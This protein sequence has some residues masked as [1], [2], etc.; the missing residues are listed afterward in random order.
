MNL[1][2]PDKLLA[3]AARTA[4]QRGRSVFVYRGSSGWLIA[5]TLTETRGSSEV[6]EVPAQTDDPERRNMGGC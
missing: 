6:I 4:R 5:M 3:Q 1:K 2:P